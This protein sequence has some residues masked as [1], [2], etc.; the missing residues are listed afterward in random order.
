MKHPNEDYLDYLVALGQQ[1][2]HDLEFEV[3]ADPDPADNVFECIEEV[4]ELY[5]FAPEDW[6]LS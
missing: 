4:T 5:P 3:E 6:V 1:V 2:P